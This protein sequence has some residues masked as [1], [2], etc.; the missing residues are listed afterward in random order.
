M[1]AISNKMLGKRK[2]NQFLCLRKQ[3]KRKKIGKYKKV[4][5]AE[6]EVVKQKYWTKGTW[7]KKDMRERERERETFCDDY[8]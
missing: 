1:M 6:K 4:L 2:N 7:G 3:G 5:K 8:T